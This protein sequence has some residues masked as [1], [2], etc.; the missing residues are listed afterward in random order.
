MKAGHDARLLRRAA[1][2]V[3][4]QTAL[5]VAL[6]VVV[7]AFGVVLLY[8]HQQAGEVRAL[9][10]TTA[11]TAD[12]VNDPPAGVWIVRLRDGS[13]TAND[14]APADVLRAANLD[15][16]TPGSLSIRTA[17][18]SLPGWVADRD[19]ARFVAVYDQPR[20]SVEEHR[21]VVSTVLAGLVGILLAAA[22]GLLVGRRAVRPLGEAMDLQR[23]FVADASH[24]L[25]TPLAVLHTRAQMV[26]RHLPAATSGDLRDEVDRLVGDTSALGEVVSDLLLAAQLEHAGLPSSDVDLALVARDVV[27]SMQPYA[28]THGV[29]LELATT[30]P[31]G[32]VVNGA[33]TSLR[34]ALTALADNAIAHSEE[35]SSVRVLVE[36]A[37]SG[38]PGA[39]SPDGL[40]RVTVADEGEGLDPAD[41]EMLRQRFARGTTRGGGAGRRFG[42]GLALVD[43]VVR[44]H[45]GRLEVRGAPGRGA[46]F[47]M[48]LP[49][50][51]GP[52]N[53]G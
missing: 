29:H 14:G 15:R 42:L 36:S 45:H 25:R 4:G 34:R 37:S 53:P 23:R 38:R 30:S 2:S 41:T 32:Y 9:V 11:T 49:R 43:E 19:G 27:S 28:E 24:E 20:H 44:A 10:R 22:T 8:E 1:W 3:A 17:Q 47:T 18:G 50:R 48:L 33:Q 40:V 21:L 51:G 35:G 12:D 52:D 6:V 31:D 39:G 5:A 7:V 16:A 26:R 13:R 46:S